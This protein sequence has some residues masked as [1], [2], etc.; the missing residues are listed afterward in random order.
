MKTAGVFITRRCNLRCSYCNV[1]NTRDKELSLEQ[2]CEAIDIMIELGIEKIHFLGG[3]P[4]L[5]ESFFEILEYISSNTTLTCSF[6]TN[7]F[8][9]H[10]LLLKIINNFGKRIGVGVSIDNYDI[11][12]SI[13]PSKAQKGIK[14]IEFLENKNLLQ[15]IDLTVYIVLNKKNINEITQYIKFLSKKN[16][17]SYLLPL[18]W[19]TT[20]SQFVHRKNS[21]KNAFVS[22]ADL[23]ILNFKIQELLAEYDNLK[24][25]NSKE[26]LNI[27]P[28]HIRFLDRKC[29]QL[30]EL[31]VNCDGRIMC[32]CDK[33]GKVFE[34]YSIFSVK[35]NFDDFLKL[36][37]KNALGC[38]GCL[39]PSV[40][41]SELREKVA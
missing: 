16:I 6:T 21:N 7:G 25:T 38:K 3:E 19:D 27:I 10:E 11:T 41:E 14:V 1:Q 32:C 22:S 40:F 17:S 34:K 2:W 36:R 5:Y 9:N 4:T 12:K 13:S 8:F 26:F 39:W 20:T 18:H 35:E 37:E 31:R 33:N 23:E 28:K 30:S 29:T 15:K 24:I